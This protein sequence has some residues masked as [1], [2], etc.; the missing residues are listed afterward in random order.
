MKTELS[1]VCSKMRKKFDI[2]GILNL[3]RARRAVGSAVAV[4]NSKNFDLK[5]PWMPASECLQKL[6]SDVFFSKMFLP[7][8]NRFRLVSSSGGKI[9]GKVDNLESS[10]SRSAKFSPHSSYLTQKRIPKQIPPA[11][12]YFLFLKL[13]W[14]ELGQKSLKFHLLSVVS[15]VQLYQTCIKV[16]PNHRWFN[17]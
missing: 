12:I 8:E 5:I 16:S 6:L 1:W 17:H 3:L 4:E 9:K 15:L 10:Q 13:C 2:S 11:S 14:K 7:D